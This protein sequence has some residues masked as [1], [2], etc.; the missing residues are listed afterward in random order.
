MGAESSVPRDGKDQEDASAS[1]SGPEL[2]A[3]A[4]ALQEESSVHDS[5]VQAMM[6]Q[7]GGPGGRAGALGVLVHDHLTALTYPPSCLTWCSL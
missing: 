3:E 4:D 6:G 2:R 7:V 5:K 1:A